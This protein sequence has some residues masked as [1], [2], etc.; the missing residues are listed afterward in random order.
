MTQKIPQKIVI[1]LT[2]TLGAGKGTVVDYLVKESGFVHLSVS[3]FLAAEAERRGIESDRL[4]RQNIA[5]EYRAQGPTALMEAVYNSA[6]DSADRVVLEPQ[7]T[8]A[9]VRFVQEKG[10]IVFSVDANLETRYKRIQK[11]GSP[12]DN[13]SFE[14]F[15]RVQELEMSSSDP[16][17]NNLAAAIGA[18]D[19]HFTNNGTPDELYEAVRKVLQEKNI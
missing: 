5:N 17:K 4:A 14:E 7:H 3:E 15:A 10:G 8:P 18:A 16:N 13:V 2:G 11:R 6:D 12:K 1:G 19:V 9:E